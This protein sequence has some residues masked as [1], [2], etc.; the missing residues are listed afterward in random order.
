M[1][2]YYERTGDNANAIKQ[3]KIALSYNKSLPKS[4]TNDARIKS[5][6][7]RIKSLGG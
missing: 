5:L 7:A 6:E 1:G 3:Y 4:S 2:T